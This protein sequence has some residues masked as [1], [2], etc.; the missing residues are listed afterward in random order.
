MRSPLAGVCW[1]RRYLARWLAVFFGSMAFGV[2]LAAFFAPPRARDVQATVRLRVYYTDVP[3]GEPT[4]AVVYLDAKTL[5]EANPKNRFHFPPSGTVKRLAPGE[6]D[7]VVQPVEW[8]NGPSKPL[9]KPQ[10]QRRRW[11]R[12][13]GGIVE[14]EIHRPYAKPKR[15]P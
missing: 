5:A 6:R 3:D 2:L 8:K 7:F 11:P 9:G 13:E 10:Y 15:S 12:Q 1:P 4:G 14:F